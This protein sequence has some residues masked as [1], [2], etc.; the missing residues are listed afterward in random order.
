[1]TGKTL[2]TQI[3]NPS[4]PLEKQIVEI[5]PWFHNLHLP[6]GTQTAPAHP[7]GDFPSFK[8]KQI[9]PEIPEDLSGWT[10]LDIGCNAGFYCLELAK[11]GAIVTGID[12]D[13][14]YL[15]QANW[16]ISEFDINNITYK[17]MQ[18]YELAAENLSYDLILFMGVF[19]HLRYPLLGL[20]IVSRMFKKLMIFQTFTMPGMEY[21]DTSEDIKIEGR[22]ILLESGW[23]KMAFIENTLEGD[24]TNWWAP[25]HAAVVAMLRSSGIEVTGMPAHEIYICRH[26]NNYNNDNAEI[27]SAAQQ[28]IKAIHMNSSD[29]RKL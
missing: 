3:I 2:E 5:G 10:V 1:V 25:N 14:H 20:D 16:V 19:Y 26:N 27:L 18:I 23:P 24:E 4:S 8:W 13:D 28:A 15:R 7:L 29:E 17:K 11:R 22:E 9:A 12:I 6:D 21:I